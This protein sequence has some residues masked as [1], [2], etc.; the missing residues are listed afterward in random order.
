MKTIQ[1]ITFLINRLSASGGAERVMTVLANQ[2]VMRGIDITIIT[3]QETDCVYPLDSRVKVLS[4]AV[5]CSNKLVRNAKR[6]I[7]LRKLIVESNPDV[8]I[9]F[10]TPMNIQAAIVMLGLKY[11]LIVSERN[12]PETDIS[13]RDKF[14][15]KL[16]YPRCDGFVFQTEDAKLWFSRKIQ[17]KSVIICNPISDNL[18]NRKPVK[19]GKIVNVG[20]L[21]EQK[22][23]HMLIDA[24]KIYHAKNEIS[25]LTIY[26]IG[27]D[28][29]VLRRYIAECGLSECVTLAGFSKNVM[30]EI[31][32][33][34]LF[35]LSSN[36]E[37]MP[38]ALMEAMGIGIACISTDCPCGGP[39]CLIENG[40]NGVL[41][42]V[43]NINRMTE[44]IES[45]LSDDSWRIDME[46]E[47][48]KLRER[49]S[50]SSIAEQWLTYCLKVL[51]EK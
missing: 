40:K 39:R 42:E 14:F 23:Q 18:P 38:N 36:Y 13:K 45:V 49:L 32:D 41:V 34:E 19:K 44:A 28:E 8:V 7:L 3:R 20:R 4:T 16:M 33:A 50:A 26:G 12:N 1:R 10:M 27:K 2:F 47:S 31:A 24:F 29:D 9:S 30:E 25:T 21:T 6:N 43:D 48:K 46:R 15:L 37:G 35:V 17:N 5:S 22:N 11:P 51:G